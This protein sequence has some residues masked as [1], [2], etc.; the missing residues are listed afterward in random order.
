MPSSSANRHDEGSF[1]RAAVVVD[2]ANIVHH[3]QRIDDQSAGNRQQQTFGRHGLHR[4]WQDQIISH[5]DGH[6]AEKQ[7]NEQISHSNVGKM[8]RVEEAEQHADRADRQ[9]FPTAEE[10]QRKA[11]DA[12][13]KSRDSDCP[14]HRPSRHPTLRTSAFRTQSLFVVGTFPKIEIIVDEIRVDLHHESKQKA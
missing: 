8:G 10:N 9:H 7:Q 1:S 14:L 6:D 4:L 5:C 2:V 11:D 3:Q 12:G 13:Q